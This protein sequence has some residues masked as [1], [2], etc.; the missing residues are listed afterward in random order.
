MTTVPDDV[1]DRLVSYFR[2]QAAKGRE[3]IREAVDEGHDG[4][5]SVLDG[6]SD[7]QAKFK[8]SPDVWSVMEVLQHAATAEREVARLCATL[9]RGETYERL[10]AEGEEA[11]TQDGISRMQFGSLDEARSAAESAHGELIAFI[12]SLSPKTDVE[13]RFKH[14]IFGAL[15][16]QEWAVFQ[17]VHDGDHERQVEQIK[18]APG[19]PS[20]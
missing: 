20:A 6:M 10:G 15:N 11:S 2:H 9:A 18:A 13:T 3:A 1:R 5:V 16:C 14:F 4:L 7:E 19:F 12:D 17:R 8:P